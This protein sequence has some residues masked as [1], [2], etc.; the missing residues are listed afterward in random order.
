MSEG[1][2]KL[3]RAVVSL[4]HDLC[5]FHIHELWGTESDSRES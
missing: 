1:I 4:K 3:F 2:G 5:L